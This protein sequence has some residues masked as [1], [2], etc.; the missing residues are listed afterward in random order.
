MKCLF[1]TFYAKKKLSYWFLYKFLVI[2]LFNFNFFYNKSKLQ[3]FILIFS[4]F[5]VFFT[6]NF[7][8]NINVCIH[9]CGNAHVTLC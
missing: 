1:S 4:N 6:N 3:I 7:R 9:Q 2:F 5:L 8:K